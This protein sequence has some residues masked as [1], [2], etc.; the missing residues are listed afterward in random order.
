M[1]WK[2]LLALLSALVV[3]GVL[4][5]VSYPKFYSWLYD[6]LLACY[7]VAYRAR[8]GVDMKKAFMVQCEDSKY[9]LHIIFILF[10]EVCS[11]LRQAIPMRF[12]QSKT[13]VRTTLF[14]MGRTKLYTGLYVLGIVCSGAIVLLGERVNSTLIMTLVTF[15]LMFALGVELTGILENVLARLTFMGVFVWAYLY[16]VQSTVGHPFLMVSAFTGAA[17]GWLL[18]KWLDTH[19]FK[20]EETPDPV[21]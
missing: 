4:G 12:T 14:N 1:M 18:V 20:G 13:S 2:W 6:R 10:E 15:M 17:C 19:V 9:P 3:Q 11:N 21:E 7:P 8:F 16:I 5:F